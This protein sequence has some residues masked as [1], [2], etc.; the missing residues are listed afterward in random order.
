MMAPEWLTMRATTQR[1]INAVEYLRTRNAA[2]VFLCVVNAKADSRGPLVT[3]A[4]GRILC[5]RSAPATTL[6]SPPY[7]GLCPQMIAGS[8]IRGVMYNENEPKMSSRVIGGMSQLDCMVKRDVSP[9]QG[10]INELGRVVS[11]CHNSMA[12]LADRLQVVCAPSPIGGTGCA[13]NAPG[14][15]SRMEEELAG[16]IDSVRQLQDRIAGLESSLRI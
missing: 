4:K 10:C 8:F 9:I 6:V 11:G 12:A 15:P 1:G 14:T 2:F 7:M 16:L 13:G 5:R 3:D